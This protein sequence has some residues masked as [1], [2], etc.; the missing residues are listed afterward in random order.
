[1]TGDWRSTQE[2]WRKCENKVNLWHNLS[3]KYTSTTTLSKTEHNLRKPIKLGQIFCST[4]LFFCWQTPERLV[5]IAPKSSDIDLQAFSFSEKWSWCNPIF[6]IDFTSLNKISFFFAHS[7][8]KLVYLG[9]LLLQL[10]TV[11]N[12]NFLSVRSSL[13][14]WVGGLSEAACQMRRAIPANALKV[15]PH[16]PPPIHDIEGYKLRH[17]LPLQI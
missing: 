8:L 5:W 11:V 9:V 12:D 7:R 17:L 10:A 13:G 3:P 4:Y 14:G 1:M 6:F 2:L 16:G 15:M